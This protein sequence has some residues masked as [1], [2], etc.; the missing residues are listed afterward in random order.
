MLSNHFIDILNYFAI[1]WGTGREWVD[2]GHVTQK[3][4]G[5][6]NHIMSQWVIVLKLPQFQAFNY[7][8]GWKVG[9]RSIWTIAVICN[10]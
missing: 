1:K 5:T 8:A 9:G 10:F 3:L 4:F 2:R 7:Y 6:F